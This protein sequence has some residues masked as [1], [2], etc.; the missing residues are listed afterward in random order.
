[1]DMIIMDNWNKTVTDDDIVYHLGDVAFG[2][3]KEEYYR[4][5]A[6][7]FNGIKFFIK[8][9][10]DHSVKKMEACGLNVD[11]GPRVLEEHKLIISHKPMPD[12]TILDGYVNVHGHIHNLPLDESF[13][14]K[15]HYCVCQELND[16]K[17]ISLEKILQELH[18]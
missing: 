11:Y 1:M 16:Y 3:D 17:P 5:V 7:K 18:R 2:P 13:D 10:H 12:N 9:N 15:K 4:H 8:G 6:K 14:P